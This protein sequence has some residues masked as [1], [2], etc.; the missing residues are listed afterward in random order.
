VNN[1]PDATFAKF[2]QLTGFSIRAIVNN[3]VMPTGRGDVAFIRSAL[4]TTDGRAKI[5]LAY[6]VWHQC[7]NTCK[8]KAAHR[9]LIPAKTICSVAWCTK[10]FKNPIK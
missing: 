4:P 7:N 1:N 3:F 10:H 9:H 6:Q 8:G 2:G 5:C